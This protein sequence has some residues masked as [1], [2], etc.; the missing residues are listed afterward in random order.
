MLQDGS[1]IS[2]GGDLMRDLEDAMA[3]QRT[4]CISGSGLTASRENRLQSN[5]QRRLTE[6]EGFILFAMNSYFV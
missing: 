4:N 3:K 2:S 1:E 6:L 5:I